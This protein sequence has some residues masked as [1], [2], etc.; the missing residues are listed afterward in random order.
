MAMSALYYITLVSEYSIFE[1]EDDVV[2]FHLALLLEGQH[3]LGALLRE[4]V[5]HVVDFDLRAH[6][7]IH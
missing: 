5:G 7:R 6:L 4:A 2:V 3:L 1:C